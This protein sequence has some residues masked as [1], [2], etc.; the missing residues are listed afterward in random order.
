MANTRQ[1]EKAL[2]TSPSPSTVTVKY[3]EKREIVIK[4]V[5]SRQRAAVARV[6]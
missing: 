5:M 2:L 4:V 1:N 3:P 6:G